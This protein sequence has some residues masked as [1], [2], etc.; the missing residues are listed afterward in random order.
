MSTHSVSLTK[1]IHNQ[2]RNIKDNHGITMGG[3]AIVA[4]SEILDNDKKIESIVKKIKENEWDK[5]GA[6][7]LE[8]LGF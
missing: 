1:N 4:L 8:N 2:I 6:I 7:R 3:F 5:S